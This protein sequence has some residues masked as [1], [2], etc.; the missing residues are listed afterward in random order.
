MCGIAGIIETTTNASPQRERV[1]AMLDA[2]PHRGPDDRGIHND[3]PAML[4]QTRLSI[5]DLA[6][7]R[8]PLFNEDE[9][10]AVVCNGEIYNYRE[11]REQLERSGHRFRTNSDCEVLPHLWEQHGPAMLDHLRGM[12]AFVLY[13]RKQNRIFGARDHFGQKPLFYAQSNERFAFASESKA[14]LTL[15][16][17]SRE[18]DPAALDQFL[19][20]KYLPAPATLF[21]SVRQLPAGH[22]F[23]LADG[24]LSVRRYWQPEYKAGEP[25]DDEEY[26]ERLES[27]VEQSVQRHLVS[28]V[29]VAV[30]L[31]GG[32]DSS[33]ITAIA[34]KSL[35]QRMKSFSISFPDSKDDESQAAERASREFGTEHH[36]ISFRPESV[37]ETLESI[38]RIFDQPL[39][40]SAALPLLHLS[41]LAAGQVKVVLTGDGGDE[42]FGGYR[43]YRRA[44]A[45][46]A[47][48]GMIL[49]RSLFAT[50][51]TAACG[52]DP[53]RLR[54]AW[55]RLGL[56][57]APTWRTDYQRK[58]WEGWH[59]HELY[60]RDFAAGVPRRFDEAHSYID[61]NNGLHPVHAMLL[62]DQ[63]GALPNDLLHKTDYTTMAHSLESRAP[64]LDV[65]LFNTASRL[66]PHLLVSSKQT[67]VALRRIAAGW[68]PRELVEK[69]KKGFSFSIGEWFR[70]PLQNWVRD[71]LINDSETV[72]RYFRR[73][74]VERFL[75]EH[76]AGKKDHRGRIYSLLCFELWH[77]N[78]A[79]V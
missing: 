9:S 19:F 62:A 58:H 23:E 2:M 42:I 6:G 14:L 72:P 35:S 77:R 56:V 49:S 39:A 51:R 16:D 67:K 22:C 5:I 66:P 32:I 17:V 38:G 68:L 54:K 43:K 4:G 41:Q 76:N 8:Q 34:A 13:D 31:S 24:Q 73:E 11:L 30:F 7:G 71:C 20:Y 25:L 40:D 48:V 45:P 64:F 44:I 74:V 70:G 53:L 52:A 65:D 61:S 29:P 18:I 33:L 63:T 69:P 75:S 3:G 50:R 12:F 28:D 10:I 1:E 78:F 47:K 26:L 57:V 60:R 79:G 46:A 55:S 36:T 21:E 59:R 15:P 37:R 27:A